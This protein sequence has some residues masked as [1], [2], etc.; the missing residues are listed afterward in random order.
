MNHQLIDKALASPIEHPRRKLILVA[1]AHRARRKLDLSVNPREISL[2]VGLGGD[3][4]EKVVYHIKALDGNYLD[5]HGLLEG[6]IPMVKLDMTRLA[7][8]DYFEDIS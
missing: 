7:A 1:L 3:G 4:A 8:M 5:S 6:D 2:C